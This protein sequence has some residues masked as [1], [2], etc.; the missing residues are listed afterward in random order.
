MERGTKEINED[1]KGEWV[2]GSEYKWREKEGIVEHVKPLYKS[3]VLMQCKLEFFATT[4]IR[5]SQGL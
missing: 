3:T 1:G 5:C 2:S 4:Q